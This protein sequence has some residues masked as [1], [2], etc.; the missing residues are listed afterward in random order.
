MAAK[1]PQEWRLPEDI[2]RS[3]VADVSKIPETCGILS[4]EEVA[5]T[6]KDS[7]FLLEQMHSG[8]ISSE[9]VV[10]AFC[11]R[12]AIAQQL[13]RCLTQ[14]CFD[15]ALECARQLDRSFQ[16]TGQIQGPLHGLPISI[17]DHVNVTG[18]P[19]TIGYCGLADNIPTE[20]AIVVKALKDA[21]AIVF[22]K[23]TMP[24]TGMASS[25][26]LSRNSLTVDRRLKRSVSYSVE[27]SADSTADWCPGEVPAAKAPS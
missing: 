2:I 4:K 7:T 9:A 11:K 26:L 16:S 3:D 17:K 22:V 12:A 6:A 13:V 5:I 8:R 25:L 14:I 15:E 1:I 21:G 23:T 27:R 10:L 18:L 20:D 24:V 19:S